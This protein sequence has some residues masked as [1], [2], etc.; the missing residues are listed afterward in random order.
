MC[1]CACV[2]AWRAYVHA[3]VFVPVCVGAWRAYVHACVFVP[4]CVGACT[5]GFCVCTCVCVFRGFGGL[6]RRVNGGL[7][8]VRRAGS[9]QRG[10]EMTFFWE[11][12][13]NLDLLLNPYLA[14][15]E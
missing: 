12:Y 9:I 7:W 1:A 8:R 10:G 14:N 13:A 6:G 3:C 15:M 2:C 5:G 11:L 4:V